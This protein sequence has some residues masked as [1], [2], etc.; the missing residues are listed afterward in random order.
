[1]KQLGHD[2]SETAVWRELTPGG[3]IV[4]GGTSKEFRTGDWRSMR[5]VVLWDKCKHCLLCAPACPDSS[6]SVTGGRRQDFDYDHCKGCG[7]CAQVCPF[8]AI[9]MGKESGEHGSEG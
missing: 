1:M 4:G 9:K 3:L 7:I 6:I 8:G 2:I 5:P